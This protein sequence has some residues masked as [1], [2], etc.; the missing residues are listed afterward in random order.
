MVGI[1]G[2]EVSPDVSSVSSVMSSVVSEVSSVI[3]S[4]VSEVSSV[5]S[6]VVVSV[7]GWVTASALYSIAVTPLSER[8]PSAAALQP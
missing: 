3:S 6:S 4:V 2:A 1:V 5:M 7:V 8:L